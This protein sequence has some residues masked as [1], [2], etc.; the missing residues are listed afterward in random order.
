MY[1]T[2]DIANR[3]KSQAKAEKISLKDMLADCDMNVNSISEFG[4]G[5]QMSCISLALIA[6]YLGCS[7]DY[8]L[9]RTDTPAGLSDREAALLSAY[10]QQPEMQS[11]VDK[12]LGVD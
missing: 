1:I 9:G 12:L 7:V 6:D 11:A 3:I 5:K 10:R 2:R 4:K 8:L